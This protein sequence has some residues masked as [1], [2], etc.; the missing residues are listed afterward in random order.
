MRIVV[1]GGTG[2]LGSALV[3][4][5]AREDHEV[6]VLSRRAPEAPPPG[7]VWGHRT[8]VTHAG[9]IVDQEERWA[10]VLDGADVLVNLAGESIAARR[11]TP[12][13]KGRLAESRLGTVRALG[14]ALAR[15]AAPPRLFANAS[16]VGYYGSRDDEI[17]TE[18]SPPGRGFL[19]DLCVQWEEAARAAAPRGTRV[20]LLRTG[21]VLD[22]GGGA[23]G[24]MLT[25]F[26]LGLGGPLGSGRQY[27]P[28]IHRADWVR[29]VAWLLARHDEGPFNLTAPEPVT[30]EAFTRALAQAIGR[31]A[32]LRAPAFA[33]RL[34]LGE[35]ADA[36]LLSGQRAI[37]A[38]AQ[39]LG[40]AFTYPALPAALHAIL[41]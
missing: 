39:A 12:A 11:W 28:W 4:A 20:V 29:L 21:L 8:G 6:V 24:S 9:W 19:S 37:P 27:M 5:L 32:F 40:F 17:L 2:F 25:P 16:A 18:E 31:P 15:V 7:Q 3:E 38:R 22:R 33:L 41:A 13:Q 36:L 1:A 35:M 34:A 14:R 10:H 30:N 26:R 23:L